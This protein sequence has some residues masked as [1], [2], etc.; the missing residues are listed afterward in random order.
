MTPFLTQFV[1]LHASNNTRSY[2]PKYWGDG[3]MGRPPT[4]HFSAYG[5]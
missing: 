4:S 2:F 5:C 3:C 1:L